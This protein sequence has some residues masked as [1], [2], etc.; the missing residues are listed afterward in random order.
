MRSKKMS[1]ETWWI[2]N[3]LHVYVFPPPQPNLFT[4]HMAGK[5]SFRSCRSCLVIKERTEIFLVEI[6]LGRY[7]YIIMC[8]M[9]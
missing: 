5:I 2:K 7:I 4:S 6:F 3:V 8:E 1:V 9:K